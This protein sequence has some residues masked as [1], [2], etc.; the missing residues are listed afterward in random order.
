MR[1]LAARLG[2][3]ALVIGLGAGVSARADEPPD[4]E[5]LA[6]FRL[7]SELVYLRDLA[8]SLR[9]RDLDQLVVE[10][11]PG[12]GYR[13]DS[14]L[15]GTDAI[16]AAGYLSPLPLTPLAAGEQLGL[17]HDIGL[18]AAGFERELAGAADSLAALLGE[19]PS[20]L[21]YPYHMHTR[22][23]M[24]RL[25]D[26]GW[27]CA[28]DGAPHGTGGGEPT[29]AFLLG[30]HAQPAWRENWAYWT[31]WE[32][33][34]S[35]GLTEKAIQVAASPAEMDLLLHDTPAYNLLHAAAPQSVNVLT[36]G[37][38]SVAD[39]WVAARCCVQVYAHG[40]S[41]DEYHLDPTHLAWLADA[42]T[43]DGRFWIA[44]VSEAAAWAAARHAPSEA[45][46]LIWH[47]LPEYAG[48]PEPW[49]GHPA[50]FCFST[51]DGRSLNLAYADTLAARGLPMTA[52]ITW[53][54]LGWPQ[55]DHLSRGDLL[56]LQAR[57]N[58]EIGTH[59]LSHRR[60]V[61]DQAFRFRNVGART[62]ACEISA[63][64]EERSLRIYGARA[65]AAPPPAAGP[66]LTLRVVRTPEGLCRFDYSLAE[67]QRVQL[68]LFDGQ[69]RRLGRLFAGPREAGSASFRWDGRDGKGRRLASGVYLVRLRGECAAVSAKALLLR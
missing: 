29:A 31:P 20:A 32:L 62:L 66:E 55:G 44:T 40:T 42:L 38:P 1:R 19:R 39:L 65:S 21:A 16:F 30:H 14:L 35:T 54:Y 56:D 48:D 10:A 3:G 28:R 50:A 18:D 49:N 46:S 67:R 47:P 41:G 53:D 59:G 27:C 33:A 15:T 17:K 23:L 22:E 13:I 61:P 11:V 45:D 36:Y 69:G 37:Y 6:E 60:L 12:H 25:R 4:W 64:R 68:D 8:D 34:L 7:G 63:G 5:L 2:W 51:D 24:R 43:A 26:E 52:F 9:A 58:V 57:G